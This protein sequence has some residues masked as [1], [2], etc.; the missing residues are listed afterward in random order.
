MSF[1]RVNLFSVSLL[2]LSLTLQSGCGPH[3]SQHGYIPSDLALEQIQIGSSKQK[4]DIVMGTPSVQTNAGG[5]VY[6]YISEVRVKDFFG[7]VTPKDRN[8]LAVRF[9]ANDRVSQIASYG[10]ADGRIVSFSPNTSALEGEDEN[11][12][13]SL[14]SSGS[15]KYSPLGF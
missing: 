13:K 6:Y 1:S 8:I 2:V 4:V 14:F 3:V 12:L 15:F 7:K 10:L 9:D 5:R 11:F